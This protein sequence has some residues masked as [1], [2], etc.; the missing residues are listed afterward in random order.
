MFQPRFNVGDKVVIRLGEPFLAHGIDYNGLTGTV[1]AFD[2]D[3]VDIMPDTP[4]PGVGENDLGFYWSANEVFLVKKHYSV[5]D[6]ED[7]VSS[8]REQGIT[9]DVK[10]TQ[11]VTTT[12]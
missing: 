9:V 10:V 7:V 2:G 11:T 12:L 8:L 3:S 1:R 4:R 6:L 5:N